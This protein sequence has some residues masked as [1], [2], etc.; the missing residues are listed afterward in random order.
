MNTQIPFT[1][2]LFVV[3]LSDIYAVLLR[4]TVEI[5]LDAPVESVTMIF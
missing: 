3:I 5:N 1:S 2:Q 4:E